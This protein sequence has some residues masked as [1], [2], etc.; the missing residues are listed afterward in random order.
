[1]PVPPTPSKSTTDPSLGH[2]YTTPIALTNRR[3]A[4]GIQTLPT[5]RLLFSQSSFTSPN[6]VFILR[7]LEHL[8]NE[9]LKSETTVSFKD[10]PVQIT[11]LTEDS[12]HN[13]TLSKGEE[14]W[15]KG[16]DDKDVQG[17]VLKPRG[18]K[19]GEKKKWPVLL[20]IHGGMSFLNLLLPLDS[21]N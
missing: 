20:L 5:G 1:M 16:A 3:A 4:S 12:L 19:A 9:I 21:S 14:F 8:E 6:D 13:K 15:F 18:W 17:W 7:D 11:R 10:E 2:K